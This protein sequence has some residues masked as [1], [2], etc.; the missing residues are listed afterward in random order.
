MTERVLVTGASGFLGG[1]CA[2]LARERGAT[3]AGTYH[4][5]DPTVDLDRSIQQSLPAVAAEAIASFDPDAVVHAAAMARPEECAAD[6]ATAEA[7]NV[8]GSRE[9]AAAAER[10]G[11]ELAYVSTNYVYGGAGT[12][13]Y[14]EGDDPAPVQTYGETKLAGERAVAAA[15]PDP[16]IVRV[17]DL[18]GPGPTASREAP[19]TE[20]ASFAWLLDALDGDGIELVADVYMCPTDVIATATELLDLLAADVTGTV[21][22][23]GSTLCNR[24]EF[25]HAIARAFDAP[26][27]AIEPCRASDLWDAERPYCTALSSTRFPTGTPRTMASLEAGLARF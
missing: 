3:V 11:A 4:T 1:W 9:L 7:T 22:R 8:E 13:P 21:H 12:P 5:T 14:R 2:R 25:A 15:H 17:S 20:S 19:S 10:V 27:D 26:T 24:V 18:F 23:S 16:L 6:P